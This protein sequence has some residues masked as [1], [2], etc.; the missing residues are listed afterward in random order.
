MK[1]FTLNVFKE[2]LFCL[3]LISD[4]TIKVNEKKNKNFNFN[5]KNISSLV[6]LKGSEK[7]FYNEN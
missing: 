2:T 1:I 4:K 5:L 3:K 6:H 7:S